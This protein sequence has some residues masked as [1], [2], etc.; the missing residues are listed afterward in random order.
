MLVCIRLL[1]K[2]PN[3]QIASIEVYHGLGDWLV[4][5]PHSGMPETGFDA[6]AAVSLRARLR[7]GS[8]VAADFACAPTG[9]Q[10]RLNFNTIRDMRLA[11]KAI[12]RRDLG[13]IV[14]ARSAGPGPRI[15]FSPF[16]R[17]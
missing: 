6:D 2:H 10:F 16:Y 4:W 7:D 11:G 15:C 5:P 3:Q 14:R 13:A 9:G 12:D 1:K 8:L 17:V